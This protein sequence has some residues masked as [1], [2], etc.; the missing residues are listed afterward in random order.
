MSGPGDVDEDGPRVA[1]ANKLHT[2]LTDDQVGELFRVTP[3]TVSRWRREGPPHHVL[4]R[5][6]LIDGT[7]PAWPGFRILDGEIITPAG[8]RLSA[9]SLENHRWL[10]GVLRDEAARASAAERRL[11]AAQRVQTAANDP[12]TLE[13]LAELVRPGTAPLAANDGPPSSLRAPCSD[14]ADQLPLALDDPE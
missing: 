12:S 5:L 13:S 6:S 7:H 9:G 11:E 3:R 10:V 2:S 4:E 8:D 14:P 1:I